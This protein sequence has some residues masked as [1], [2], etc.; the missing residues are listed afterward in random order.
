MIQT[1]I[2]QL[3]NELVK[4]AYYG[5]LLIAIRR[6]LANKKYEYKF[7]DLVIRFDIITDKLNMLY[8][9][10]IDCNTDDKDGLDWY[11]DCINT[12]SFM[13]MNFSVD[14]MELKDLLKSL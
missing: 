2:T 13:L 14:V 6:N 7:K 8:R 4:V 10:S 5:D 1:I 3:D 11:I 9:L 12:T